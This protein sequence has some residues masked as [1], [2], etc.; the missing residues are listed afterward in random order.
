MRGNVPCAC[1][2]EGLFK[3]SVKNQHN[4]TGDT[5]ISCNR[6]TVPLSGSTCSASSGQSVTSSR[7]ATVNDGVAVALTWI[8]LQ[9]NA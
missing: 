2:I 3:W 1:I 4:Y 6:E 8:V 7:Y 9:D 5:V